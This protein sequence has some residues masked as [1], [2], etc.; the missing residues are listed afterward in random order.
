[1]LCIRFPFSTKSL[2]GYSIV[3]ILE[4]IEAVIEFFIIANLLSFGIGFL[5][6]AIFIAEERKTNVTDINE[7]TK[8]K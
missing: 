3:V 8:T 7:C 5:T 4:Y 2:L 1:M 6:L